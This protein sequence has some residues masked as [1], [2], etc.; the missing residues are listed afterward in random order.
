MHRATYL[1]RLSLL[2]ERILTSL[3][4]GLFGDKVLWLRDLVDLLLIQAG[5]VDLV[6]GGDDVSR[7]D[8][9]ERHTIDLEGACDEENTLVEGLEEDDALATEAARKE[10]QDGAGLE[11]LPRSPRADGLANLK[12]GHVSKGDAATAHRRQQATAQKPAP[13]LW[14]A[15]AEFTMALPC[16]AI[17]TRMPKTK[18]SHQSR[19]GALLKASSLQRK[20]HPPVCGLGK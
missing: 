12:M 9:S 14:E 13:G 16:R 18:P 17:P 1:R 10:D 2:E 20:L 6:G 4:L 5:D 8:P 15:Q 19:K 3:L 7:V 11:R